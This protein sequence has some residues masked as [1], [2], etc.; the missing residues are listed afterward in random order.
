MEVMVVVS[1]WSWR[2]LSAWEQKPIKAGKNGFRYAGREL[3]ILKEN[4][5]EGTW[6]ILT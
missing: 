5:V 2:N 4:T 3:T 1:G 6:A